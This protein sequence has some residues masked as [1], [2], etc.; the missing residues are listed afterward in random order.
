MLIYTIGL[1]AI[2]STARPGIPADEIFGW[3]SSAYEAFLAQLKEED[4]DEP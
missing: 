1:S 4:R 2:F 3:Q